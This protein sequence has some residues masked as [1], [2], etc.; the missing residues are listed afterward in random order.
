MTN[1]RDDSHQ[2]D[3]P[4]NDAPAD[5]DVPSGSHDPAPAEVVDDE[6]DLS[7]SNFPADPYRRDT[8]DERLAEELPDR[9]GRIDVG[10][11]DLVDEGNRDDLAE[12]EEIDQEDALQSPAE[13]AEEAAIHIID[14]DRL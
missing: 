8:L 12:L 5:A 1:E 2:E 6:H 7:G 3:L 14:E 13:S 4:W 9:P 11:V 10:A